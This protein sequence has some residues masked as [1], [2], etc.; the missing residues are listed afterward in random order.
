[1]GFPRLAEQSASAKPPTGERT[2]MRASDPLRTVK[3]RTMLRHVPR[4]DRSP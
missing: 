2:A 4:S 3:G 1:M